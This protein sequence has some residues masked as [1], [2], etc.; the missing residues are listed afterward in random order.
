MYEYFSKIFDKKENFLII[1]VPMH[2]KRFKQ[3]KY[4]HM[5][6]VADELSKLTGWKVNTKLIQRIKETKPQYKLNTKEREENLKNAFKVTKENYNGEKL[7]LIDDILTTGS[8]LTEIIKTLNKEGITNIVG[9]TTS[10][11]YG[12]SVNIQ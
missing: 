2:K 11:V 5:D 10:C 3:R 9:L 4:N 12:S 8:T 6:L 7:L 1:P